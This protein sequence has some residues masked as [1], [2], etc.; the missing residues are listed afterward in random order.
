M[1]KFT[2]PATRFTDGAIDAAMEQLGWD[3]AAV[4]AVID[5]GLTGPQTLSALG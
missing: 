3:V 4:R 1:T 2:D 5:V